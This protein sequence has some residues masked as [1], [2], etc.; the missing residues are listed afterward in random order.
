M[1]AVVV[2]AIYVVAFPAVAGS[3]LYLY[4]RLKPR[5]EQDLPVDRPGHE[6]WEPAARDAELA[7][8]GAYRSGLRMPEGLAED[9]TMRLRDRVEEKYAALIAEGLEPAAAIAQAISQAGS[10]TELAGQA[11]RAEQTWKRLAAG[12]IG[13]ILASPGAIWAYSLLGLA[14]A[15][16]AW[17]TSRS[18]PTPWMFRDSDPA[19]Q[20]V[21]MLGLSIGFFF[22][23]RTG[24][25]ICA[26]L[27]HRSPASFSAA[28]ALIGTPIVLAYILLVPSVQLSWL[29]LVTEVL[30]PIGFA[31]GAFYRV[32]KPRVWLPRLE[33]TG[34]TVTIVLGVTAIV[35]L[36]F[37]VGFSKIGSGFS[38]FSS[39]YRSD[40]WPLANVS[41]RQPVDGPLL[42][43]FNQPEQLMAWYQVTG[44]V[45]D[46][47]P[48]PGW[49]DLRF[50]VWQGVEGTLPNLHGDYIAIAQAATGPVLIA[51]ASRVSN[52]EAPSHSFLMYDH[53]TG[54][55]HIGLRRDGPIWYISLTGVGPD[56]VRYRLADPI[57]YVAT[58][59]GTAW[60][61][62]T[63]PG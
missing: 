31:A 54:S 35:G 30:A 9:L 56:G 27:S 24:I 60:D 14:L 48:L 18:V 2:L 34:N 17:L 8:L 53:L 52:P 47:D 11:R 49:T 3:T 57:M 41:P 29:M 51:P 26:A 4:S 36:V 43:A 23:A 20:A 62:L 40:P 22:L 58:V 13:G 39:D 19:A 1:V 16:P 55:V 63:A 37:T 59:Q 61:W 5:L 42:I 10:A 25:R 33:G 28:W 7:Y 46:V 38:S 50:E 21:G 15:V 12:V 32:T 44:E 45:T 6:T